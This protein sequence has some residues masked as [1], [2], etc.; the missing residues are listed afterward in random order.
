MAHCDPEG[1]WNSVMLAVGGTV[2]AV[3]TEG[4]RTIPIDE[5]SVEGG[6]L[7]LVPGDRG[8]LFHQTR[9]VS[10]SFTDR[11]QMRLG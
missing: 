6:L 1:D 4:E 2:V 3:S 9:A 5:F 8:I 10:L 11:L 7:V